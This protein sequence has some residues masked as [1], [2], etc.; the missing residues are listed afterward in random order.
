M[1]Y[2]RDWVTQKSFEFLKELKRQFRFVLI[3]GWAVWLYTKQLKS[4]DIDI[5]VE[6]AQLDYLKAQYELIKNDRLKKY[7]IRKGEVEVDVYTPYYSTLGIGAEDIVADARIKD[8]FRVPSR[9]LLTT[10]KIVAWSH[11]RAS[12]KGQKDLLDIISLLD[13]TPFDPKALGSRVKA[14]HLE[15]AV[16][17]LRQELQ[18][19]SDFHELGLTVHQVS[20]RKKMWLALLGIENRN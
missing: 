18:K 20:R 12:A 19:R 13:S 9:E 15:E 5:V 2:Y 7:E 8:G 6:L 3:G 10:L 11:R 17:F 4:K 1:D 16:D 14:S